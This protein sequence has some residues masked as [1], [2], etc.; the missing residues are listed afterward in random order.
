MNLLPTIAGFYENNPQAQRE[1]AIRSTSLAAMTLMLAA[2]D[3]GYAT[4]PMI[5]FDPAKVSE[6]VGLDEEHIPVMLVV[7]GKE[8]GTMRP[9]AF[10]FPLD[11][12]VKLESMNGKGLE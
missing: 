9:R 5:G 10:R 8:T 7:L 1:E 4:C 6:I 3:M 11:R 12:F 2:S